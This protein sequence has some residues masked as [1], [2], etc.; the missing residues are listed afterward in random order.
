MQTAKKEKRID[1]WLDCFDVTSSTLVITRWK[2][3][4]VGLASLSSVLAE[5]RCGTRN[6]D[7]MQPPSIQ[8]KYPIWP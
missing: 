6:V 4:G 3:S 2:D 1:G 8:K 5:A 7:S